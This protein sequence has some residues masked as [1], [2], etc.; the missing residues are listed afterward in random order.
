MVWI[1]SLVISAALLFGVII[2]FFPELC[3]AFIAERWSKHFHYF[4]H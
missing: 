2:M 4:R 3:P 1:L